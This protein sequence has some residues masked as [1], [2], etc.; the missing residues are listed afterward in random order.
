MK[1][2]QFIERPLKLLRLYRGRLRSDGMDNELTDDQEYAV[3]LTVKE[4]RQFVKWRK[5]N[6]RKLAKR[7]RKKSRKSSKRNKRRKKAKKTVNSLGSGK[8]SRKQKKTR[9]RL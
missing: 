5:R 3:C 7:L 9:P 2:V 4:W 8:N 6:R 1:A